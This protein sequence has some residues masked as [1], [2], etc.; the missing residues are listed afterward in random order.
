MANTTVSSELVVK[1]YLSDFYSEVDRD[2]ETVN[3][4]NFLNL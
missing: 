1:K 2:W 3:K 4:Y